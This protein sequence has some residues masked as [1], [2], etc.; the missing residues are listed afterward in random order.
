MTFGSAIFGSTT[1][2]GVAHLKE[3]AKNAYEE[4]KGTRYESLACRINK[5]IYKWTENDDKSIFRQI[6]RFI[7]IIHKHMPPEEAEPMCDELEII[8]AERNVS[9][10][11]TTIMDDLFL[12]LSNTDTPEQFES[13]R[14]ELVEIKKSL[15][16]AIR[17]EVVVTS[18]LNV[19]GTGGQIVTSYPI[20]NIKK[21][22]LKKTIDNGKKSIGG[23]V[24]KNTRS[25]EKSGLKPNE[26]KENE[27]YS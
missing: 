21:S 9:N 8:K 26:N 24:N 12:I 10:L 15:E 16:P 1:F 19:M 18:G 7:K 5:E 22:N 6:E 13:L 2:G 25:D 27:K 23:F 4:A 20:Q 11:L 14:K 17:Q 3:A